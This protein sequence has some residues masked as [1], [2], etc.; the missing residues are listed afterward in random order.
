[1][2]EVKGG[3]YKAG[4]YIDF[5]ADGYIKPHCAALDK[6]FPQKQAAYSLVTA[7]DFFAKS[8]Q[9]H[10]AEWVEATK[11]NPPIFQFATLPLPLS[12]SRIAANIQSYATQFQPTDH[13]IAAIV[14]HLQPDNV[15]PNAS[16]WSTGV[17]EWPQVPSL[18]RTSC[19]PDVGSGTHAPGWDVGTDVLDGTSHLAAYTLGS[20]FPEDA[21]LCAALSSYWAA[22]APDS[23]RVFEPLSSNRTV[24]P[25]LDAEINWDGTAPAESVEMGEKLLTDFPRYDYGDYV[26]SALEHK[27]S[28][29]LTGQV[30][31]LEYV[32]RLWAMWCVNGHL[33]FIGMEW[34]NWSPLSVRRVDK[35]DVETVKALGGT[36]EYL[37]PQSFRFQV[38]RYARPLAPVDAPAFNRVRAEVLETRIYI[39]DPIARLMWVKQTDF[40]WERLPAVVSTLGR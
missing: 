36:D 27:F 14:A 5:T 29:A 34:L 8:T 30:D 7:P 3:N 23:A 13:T 15:K 20:P 38:C 10:V 12:D 9:R 35:K 2:Q 22:V 4:H 16:P 11:F 24:F 26:Q 6:E 18:Q 21:K 32:Q 28:L 31:S 25:M 17:F 39:V 19:L 40:P 33:G 1:M 37:N